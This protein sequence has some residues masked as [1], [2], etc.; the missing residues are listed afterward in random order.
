VAGWPAT[1][2][3]DYAAKLVDLLDELI[4]AATD[5]DERNRL[6]RFREA[7]VSVGTGVVTGVL[8]DLARRGI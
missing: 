3:A 4:E 1:P 5:D 7:V 6:Q 8:T 2:G